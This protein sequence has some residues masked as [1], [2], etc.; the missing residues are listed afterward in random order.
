MRYAV[1]SKKKIVKAYCLGAGSD[2]EATLIREGAIKKSRMVP[3][4][5]LVRR[6]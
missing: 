1:K 6:R 5:C 3:M 2:M 4:S